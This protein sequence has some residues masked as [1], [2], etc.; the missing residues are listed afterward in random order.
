MARAGE[1][2]VLI[3][4]FEYQSNCHL[5]N[6][7]PRQQCL[8]VHVCVCV[9]ASLWDSERNFAKTFGSI[10]SDVRLDKVERCILS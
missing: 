3:L 1:F 5:P 9:R 7:A 2:P 10:P 8:C 4:Y 6:L